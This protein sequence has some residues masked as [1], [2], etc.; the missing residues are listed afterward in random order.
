M[1]SQNNLIHNWKVRLMRKTTIYDGTMIGLDT[2]NLTIQKRKV[3]RDIIRH[4]GGAA[5][6]AVDKQGKVKDINKVSMNV[7]V[8]YNFIFD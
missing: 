8:C 3:R 2:Y 5:I 6:R 4:P 1:N 7:A